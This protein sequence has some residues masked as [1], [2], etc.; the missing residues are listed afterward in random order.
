MLQN[1][2]SDISLFL[3]FVVLIQDKGLS[4]DALYYSHVVSSWYICSSFCVEQ[5]K[6]CK[7]FSFSSEFTDNEANCYIYG[8]DQ[9]GSVFG[10]D[11]N[12]S[13]D[14]IRI[15]DG[16]GISWETYELVLIESVCQSYNKK[17]R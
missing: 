15:E 11:M 2:I 1:V 17:L 7:R 12:L 14:L 16:K 13:D 8:S 10:E 6:F 3:Y 4:T 5:Q 9:K